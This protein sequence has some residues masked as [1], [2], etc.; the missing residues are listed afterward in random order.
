MTAT[1]PNDPT[2]LF[3]R[4]GQ[5]LQRAPRRAV[6]LD[7][8]TLAPAGDG[9]V[10]ELHHRPL[11]DNIG[12]ACGEIRLS[13]LVAPHHRASLVAH[14]HAFEHLVGSQLEAVQGFVAR[15]LCPREGFG[16]DVEF[17][18]VGLRSQPPPPL[19]Q[20]PR[21]GGA[22]QCQEGQRHPDQRISAA[23]ESGSPVN[24]YRTRSPTATAWSAMRSRLRPT[25][26]AFITSRL[27]SAPFWLTRWAMSWR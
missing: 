26:I 25:S 17:S 1:A 13:P 11:G 2:S 18:Q 5:H 27:T 19:N 3:E 24:M 15:S 8:L 16:V 4:H 14:H 7:R 21:S 10:E 12:V 23:N 20:S 9:G 22:G 6:E